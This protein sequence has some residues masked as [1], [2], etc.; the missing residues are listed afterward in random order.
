MDRA[1]RR[2]LIAARAESAEAT[3]PMVSVPSPVEDAPAVRISAPAMR[4]RER[5]RRQRSEGDRM[6]MQAARELI[7]AKGSDSMRV[8]DVATRAGYCAGR[9]YETAESKDALLAAALVE[10][11]E[12]LEPNEALTA[13]WA[14][15]L[16]GLRTLKIS[17]DLRA[18]VEQAET[19]CRERQGLARDEWLLGLAV[20]VRGVS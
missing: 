7:E 18:R 6:I 17:D 14:R 5:R 2:I 4:D 13:P 9:V 15:I 12:E 16:I 20:A 11:L 10:H 8:E 1:A 19:A 3:Q